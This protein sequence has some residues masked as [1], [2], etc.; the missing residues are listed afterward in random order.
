MII[1]DDY[2]FG[3]KK[4]KKK[5]SFVFSTARSAFRSHV[6]C[7]GHACVRVCVC[8]INTH[9]QNNLKGVQVGGVR[10]RGVVA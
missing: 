8:M 4:K 1:L 2:F 9:M 6:A 3:G 10:G 7:G 5:T